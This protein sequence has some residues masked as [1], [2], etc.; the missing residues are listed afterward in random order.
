MAMLPMGHPIGSTTGD[1]MA[2]PTWGP[3]YTRPRVG[4]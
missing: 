2:I 3:L 1:P 4:G